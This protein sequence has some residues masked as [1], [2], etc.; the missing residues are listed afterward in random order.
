MY[1]FLQCRNFIIDSLNGLRTLLSAY[2]SFLVQKVGVAYRFIEVR[3]R[4]TGH[5]RSL[6]FLQ[7]HHRNNTTTGILA[8]CRHSGYLVSLGINGSITI[9]NTARC[10]FFQSD[11]SNDYV[12]LFLSTVMAQRSRPMRKHWPSDFW[13]STTDWQWTVGYS[14][15]WITDTM[16]R[17]QYIAVSD[18]L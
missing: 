11:T 16:H 14:L 1:D 6:P 13:M 2:K 7:A 15:H 3:A 10:T 5:S 4:F 8:H 17:M 12:L 18:I 9:D